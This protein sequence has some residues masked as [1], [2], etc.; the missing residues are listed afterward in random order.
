MVK[1][2]RQEWSGAVRTIKVRS[3]VDLNMCAICAGTSHDPVGG[4][5]DPDL[6]TIYS[7]VLPFCTICKSHGAK[8]VVGRYGSNCYG[9]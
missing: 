3:G 2:G 6:K 7:S 9:R 1:S 8:T 4:E 5:V